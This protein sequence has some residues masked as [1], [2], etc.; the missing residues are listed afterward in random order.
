M[1]TSSPARVAVIGGG[2]S[3]LSAALHLARERN[4]GRP[5]E[6]Y[7]F[8]ALPRLGGVIY[9]DRVDNCVV[10]AGPDSFLTEKPQALDMARDLDLG[11]DVIGSNDSERVTYILH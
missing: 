10:E 7:L 1:H 6:E 2:I 3:G 9:S 8:E 5:I 4:A 11:G